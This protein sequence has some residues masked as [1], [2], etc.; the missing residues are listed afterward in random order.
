MF[1]IPLTHAHTG[2]RHTLMELT[3]STWVIEVQGIRDVK[4]LA[5]FADAI[6]ASSFRRN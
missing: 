6:L 4:V 3:V 1:Y 2:V 5:G